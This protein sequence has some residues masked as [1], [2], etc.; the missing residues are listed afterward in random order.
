MWRNPQETADL[1]TFIEEICNGKLHFLCTDSKKV[2]RRFWRI[3]IVI[4]VLLSRGS[5]SKSNSEDCK[6][7]GNPQT[8]R[9]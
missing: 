9:K 4:G 8:S 1:I 5:G 7:K 3:T 6:D 2:P